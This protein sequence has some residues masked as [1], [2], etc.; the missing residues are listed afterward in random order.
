MKN[1]RVTFEVFRNDG[2]KEYR[3][4][5]VEAG[6][7]KLAAVRAMIEINKIEGYATLY[8]NIHAIVEVA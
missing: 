3:P 4:V 5:V 1:Y 2:S 7:K 8:K 6:T